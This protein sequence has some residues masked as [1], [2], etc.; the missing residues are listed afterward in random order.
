MAMAAFC[1]AVGNALKAQRKALR[2]A[3]LSFIF[4]FLAFAL[5][6]C[7]FSL[8][9]I[10]TRETYFER[11]QNVWDIMTTVKDTDVDDF[12]E[13]AAVQALDGVESAIVYQKASAKRVVAEEEMSEEMK[14]FG[15]FVALAYYLAWRNVRKI[16]L[17]EVLKW[18]TM[19]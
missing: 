2:T 9:Q 7:F 14:S 18:D 3:S 19:I 8:S 5:M 6:L 10:S 16:S 4:S 1:R 12:A 11:Y 17:A 13:A 15:G